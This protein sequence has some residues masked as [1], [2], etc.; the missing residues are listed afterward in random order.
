MSGL[1]A[2]PED[3]RYAYRLLLGREPDPIGFETYCRLIEEQSVS[4]ADVAAI[5]QASEE[6]KTR[7]TAEPALIEIDFDKLKLYPWRG[8]S[9]IGGAV[10]ASGSYEPHVLP[11][12]VDRVPVG[13]TVLDVGANIGIFTLCAARKTGPEWTRVRD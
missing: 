12:F 4:A 8:D 5:L 10:Q 6:Y 2:T 3:V 11:A 1:K 7:H 13:G 9:L